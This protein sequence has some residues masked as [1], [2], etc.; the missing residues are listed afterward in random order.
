MQSQIPRDEKMVSSVKP[1]TA[2]PAMA[3]P[4]K[5]GLAAPGTILELDGAEEDIFDGE[6][7]AF[8]AF[9]GDSIGMIFGVSVFSV[10]SHCET[11]KFPR[12]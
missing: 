4:D 1:A 10:H 8:L 5:V 9:T 12:S 3:P 2:T 6:G 7:C 11:E